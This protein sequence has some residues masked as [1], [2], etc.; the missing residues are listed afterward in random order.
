MELASIEVARKVLAGADREEPFAVGAQVRKDA[1]FGEI[2]VAAWAVMVVQAVKAMAHW[3]S[4][5]GWQQ[6]QSKRRDIEIHCTGHSGCR[7]SAA[8]T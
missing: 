5:C 3:S 1:N 6:W 4:L 2:D 8:R 7:Q